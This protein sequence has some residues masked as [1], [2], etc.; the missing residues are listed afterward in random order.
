M[1]W[2]TN[3]LLS[4]FTLPQ[5]EEIL[6]FLKNKHPSAHS[7]V[8]F[9]LLEMAKGESSLASYGPDLA[10]YSYQF[11][12]TEAG[13]ICALA[14]GMDGLAFRLPLE[15]VSEAVGEGAAPLGEILLGW[16]AFN[17]FQPN[18]PTADTRA[19]MKRWCRCA[20]E[21]AENS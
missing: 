17:P 14:F 11:L 9:E 12:H 5:N 19:R 10:A 2:D 6:A 15:M 21:F 18:E 16:V 1:V 4:R 8:A 7:D 20:L 3:E 13:V